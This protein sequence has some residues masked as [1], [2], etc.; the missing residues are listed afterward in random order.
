MEHISDVRLYKVNKMKKYIWALLVTILMLN[1]PISAFTL[2]DINPLESEE[3]NSNDHW[4]VLFVDEELTTPS[5]PSTLSNDGTMWSIVES[6]TNSDL[7]SV[8]RI[9]DPILN[10]VPEP[11]TLLL[12]GFGLAG[13]IAM[14]KR[15]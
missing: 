4:N 2:I 10:S 7:K 1:S 6:E 9:P 15:L 3:S 12:F 11:T 14:K 13:V 8:V 5:L